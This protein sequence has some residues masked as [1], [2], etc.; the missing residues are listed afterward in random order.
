VRNGGGLGDGDLHWLEEVP[1]NDSWTVSLSSACSGTISSGEATCLATSH[2]SS[3]P[4]LA[5]LLSGLIA[6]RTARYVP[7]LLP[8]AS[9]S[10]AGGSSP[11]GM[12]AESMPA[13]A[14]DCCQLSTGSCAVQPSSKVAT[15]HSRPQ[16]HSM[17]RVANLSPP[18]M[19][20]RAVAGWRWGAVRGNCPESFLGSVPRGSSARGRPRSE[21]RKSARRARGSGRHVRWACGGRLPFGPTHG[22]QRR[23]RRASGRPAACTAGLL[24]P[25]LEQRIVMPAATSKRT[26]IVL[27]QQA[28]SGGARPRT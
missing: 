3:S 15:P 28:L 18:A 1:L 7:K 6:A 26:Q 17:L 14:L 12:A 9:C 4:E 5:M 16:A 10:S 27:R 8:D 19:S 21:P 24:Q 13:S 2:I 23:L 20:L 11:L 22:S 25:A